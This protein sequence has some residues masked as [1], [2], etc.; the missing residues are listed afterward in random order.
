[1]SGSPYLHCS[2][3]LQSARFFPRLLAVR[4]VRHVLTYLDLRSRCVGLG[5]T[6]FSVRADDQYRYVSPAGDK[7]QLCFICDERHT[8]YTTTARSRRA[9]KQCR[10]SR[11]HGVLSRDLRRLLTRCRLY[12]VL[13]MHVLF[14]SQTDH[15]HI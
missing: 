1:M 13:I 6:S 12:V 5:V 15:T 7:S 10:A 4:A 8:S 9:R 11:V 14:F 3:R 2:R